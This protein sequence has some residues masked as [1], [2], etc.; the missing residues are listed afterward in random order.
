MPVYGHT[1]GQV[2]MF[3]DSDANQWKVAWNMDPAT[4][5]LG[6]GEAQDGPHCPGNVDRWYYLF[7]QDEY[8]PI[9]NAN[10]VNDQVYCADNDNPDC[11]DILRAQGGVRAT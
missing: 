3:Y 2:T 6:K 7:G 1:S 9:V 11:C 8:K 5:A 4:P 10:D